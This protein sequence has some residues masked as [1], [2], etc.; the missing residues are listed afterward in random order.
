MKKTIYIIRGI[1]GENY[2]DF[3][4]RILNL[5]K[6]TASEY[7]PAK[8]HVVLTEVAPPMVSVIPFKRKKIGVISVKSESETEYSIIT[9]ETGFCGMYHVEEALPVAYEKTW[10]D[11]EITPGIC[12]LTLFNQKK[13]IDYNQF[14]DRWHNS[15]TPLSLK[16]HPLWHYNRNV[17]RDSKPVSTETWDGIVEEHV[18]SRSKLLNPFSFFGNPAVI[19]QR[20][21]AVYK[22]TK[23]FIDYPSMEPYLTREYHIKS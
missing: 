8:L 12:L 2:P 13:G 23:T 1:K 17:V 4:G 19:I 11:G 21:M 22:D 6:K 9:G 10:P 16:I 7:N 15:H 14:I 20:M 18:T 3:K 5:T